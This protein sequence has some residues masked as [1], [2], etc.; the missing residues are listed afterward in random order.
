MRFEA[1]RCSGGS[2]GTAD[3]DISWEEGISSRRRGVVVR[4]YGSTAFLPLNQG[5][6]PVPRQCV[7]QVKIAVRFL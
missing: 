7:I 6:E 2:E 1:S 4:A 5:T 3:K